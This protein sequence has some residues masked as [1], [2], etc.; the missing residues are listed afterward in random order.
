MV[1]DGHGRIEATFWTPHALRVKAER[2]KPQA[3]T[4]QIGNG[5]GIHCWNPAVATTSAFA[6]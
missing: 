6:M 3:S 2:S 4:P 5:C 1:L